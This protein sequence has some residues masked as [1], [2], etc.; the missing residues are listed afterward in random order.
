MRTAN[1]Y[2]KYDLSAVSDGKAKFKYIDKL[3]VEKER[4]ESLM[5]IQEYLRKMEKKH[6]G[7][8][9][10]QVFSSEDFA[11]AKIQW[12]ISNN[13]EHKL[14]LAGANASLGSCQNPNHK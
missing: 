14:A 2:R 7:A 4:E 9:K 8:E 3:G 6:L 5:S 10:A 11:G 1:K 12:R 13:V